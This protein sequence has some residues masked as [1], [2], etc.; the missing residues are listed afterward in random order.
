MSKYKRRIKCARNIK[1]DVTRKTSCK[2]VIQ[3]FRDIFEM[4]AGESILSHGGQ[5][6]QGSILSHRGQGRV[7]VF[8]Q[9]NQKIQQK[10]QLVLYF[11]LSIN[12]NPKKKPGENNI[13]PFPPVKA[14]DVCF[15]KCYIFAKEKHAGLYVLFI[16]LIGAFWKTGNI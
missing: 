1:Q 7:C 12:I 13:G 15:I 11:F 2:V 4:E 3:F 5:R 10:R 8:S 9:R 16:F 6:T 14:T